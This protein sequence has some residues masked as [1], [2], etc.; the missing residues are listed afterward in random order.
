MSSG[1]KLQT[2]SAQKG[3][4]E[5]QMTDLAAIALGLGKLM[6]EGQFYSSREKGI[7]C[8]GAVGYLKPEELNYAQALMD[9][10]I[11]L[12]DRKISSVACPH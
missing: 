7:N 9:L 5:E 4:F 10:K 6:I 12:A 2:S 8:I 1:I 11:E 3:K